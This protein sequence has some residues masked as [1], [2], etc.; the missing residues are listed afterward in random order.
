[1]TTRL[2]AL[3]PGLPAAITA[4]H[5][6]EALHYRLNA[7]G[8]RVGRQVQ[9]LRQAAFQGPLHVRVGNTDIIIRRS[10]AACI[11]LRAA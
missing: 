8:L 2:T 4:I 3:K 9:V 1:M 5:A 7:L 6:A 10:D 11:E